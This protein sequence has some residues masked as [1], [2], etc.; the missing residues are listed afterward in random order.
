MDEVIV[1]GAGIAGLAAAK[2]L[3]RGGLAPV[4]LEAQG[5]IGGRIHTI[6]DENAAAPIELG[7]EF[8]HG[9]PPEIF[10]AAEAA[11]IEIVRTGGKFY[12]VRGGRLTPSGDEPPEGGEDVWDK[13][14]KYADQHSQDI[15]LEA[16]L[17]LPENASIGE[18]SR[19]S[20]KRFV[21]G[22]H[23]A[24]LDK[25]GIKGLVKTT[26]AEESIGGVRA[27]RIPA[28]YDLLPKYFCESA[29]AAG[30]KL[31]LNSRVKAINWRRGSVNVSI[32]SGERVEGRAA[33]ITLP[34]GLLKSSPGSA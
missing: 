30:A 16:F 3:V 10:Q 33:I 25:V 17:N 7:A 32:E 27:F 20:L 2:E 15:S 26:E 14:E 19:D 24:E 34:G 22:F 5:R 11:G 18:D 4:V 23:A 13:I 12:V 28:G 29:R 8:V 9:L 31:L 1:A 6:H 21:A